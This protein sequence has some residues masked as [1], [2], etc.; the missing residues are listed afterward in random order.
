[1]V[2]SSRLISVGELNAIREPI[3]I[4]VPAIADL[5]KNSRRSI[6]TFLPRF[7]ADYN[8]A[9]YT[10]DKWTSSKPRSRRQNLSPLFAGIT[11]CRRSYF[12]RR[13]GDVMRL[14][15]KSP[16]INLSG[17]TQ[18]VRLSVRKY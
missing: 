17:P 8:R 1:M 12:C 16:T 5:C 13:G 3:K 6:M 2:A 14:Q 9:R 10:Y 7:S 11:Y 18:N 4:D 15:Q